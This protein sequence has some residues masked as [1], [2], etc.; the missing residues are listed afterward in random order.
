MVAKIGCGVFDRIRR[1]TNNKVGGAGSK[2]DIG[3][4]GEGATIKGLAGG[5]SAIQ[6]EVVG[7]LQAE[8]G[9]GPEG[10]AEMPLS[11]LAGKFPGYSALGKVMSGHVNKM[12]AG[13][14]PGGFSASQAKQY[15]GDERLVG[16]GRTDSI[17]CIGVSMQPGARLGSA[18]PGDGT[19]AAPA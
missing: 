11:E 5:K 1:E 3:E 18:A 4:V 17:M 12:L 15:L 9:S 13:K 2:K 8:F 10:G 6:N 16:P 19:R 14:M 7:E